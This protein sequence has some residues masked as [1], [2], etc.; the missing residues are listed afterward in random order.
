MADDAKAEDL[1]QGWTVKLEKVQRIVPMDPAE[2]EDGNLFGVEFELSGPNVDASVEVLVSDIGDEAQ[3]V[4]E[5]LDAL[6][7]GLEVLGRLLGR[8]RGAERIEPTSE[9]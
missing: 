8:R 3:V 2:A 1:D 9:R 4:V 5:A 7:D 6:Q